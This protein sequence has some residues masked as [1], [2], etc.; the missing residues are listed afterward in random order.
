MIVW[1]GKFHIFK[2]ILTVIHTVKF[3]YCDLIDIIVEI[4]DCYEFYNYLDQYLN[5]WKGHIK[6]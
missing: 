1:I 2:K 4:L 3:K 5:D 6:G